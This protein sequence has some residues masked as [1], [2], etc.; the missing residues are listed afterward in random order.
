MRR[1][2]FV[3]LV[4]PIV[5]CCFSLGCGGGAGGGATPTP[6]EGITATNAPPQYKQSKPKQITEEEGRKN[7]PQG[8]PQPGGD[9]QSR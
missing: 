6:P 3:L 7:L 5:A 2:F 4:V 8:Y 9:Q 1:T